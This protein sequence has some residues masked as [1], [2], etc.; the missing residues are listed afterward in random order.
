MEHYNA[1]DQINVG[2]GEDLSIREVAEMVRDIVHPTARLIFDSSKPDG[3]PRKLLDVQR[4]HELGWRHKT[5][6]REGLERTY[7]WFVNQLES[8]GVPPRG[9]TATRTRA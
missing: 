8:Q 4:L 9:M 5:G 2:T 6:L 3:T 7:T 1:N